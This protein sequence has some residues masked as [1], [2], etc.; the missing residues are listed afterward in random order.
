MATCK[1]CALNTHGYCM[2]FS[3]RIPI[4]HA[5]TEHQCPHWAEPQFET[6]DEVTA[7]LD[8]LMANNQEAMALLWTLRDMI[9]GQPGVAAG[10][11]AAAWRFVWTWHGFS[12]SQRAELAGWII[13]F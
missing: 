12:D 4:E 8:G 5:T 3:R 9:T 6:A 1:G 13:P 11:R 7:W 2:Q 10:W